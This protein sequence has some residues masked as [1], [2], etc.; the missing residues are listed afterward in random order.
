[1]PGSG[2]LVPL[3]DEEL[4]ELDEE[5]L[6]EDELEDELL[7]E[8]LLVDD[9]PEVEDELEVLVHF[10]LQLPEVFHVALAGT[11]TARAPRARAE[12]RILR[13]M[14]S[15]FSSK[16]VDTIIG[17][18]RAISRTGPISVVNGFSGIV[19]L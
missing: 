18:G 19:R 14:M 15:P 16:M 9:E 12:T 3:L 8:E 10:F 17:K 5:E 2:T 13:T 4:L 6:L 7:D 11:E 1:M